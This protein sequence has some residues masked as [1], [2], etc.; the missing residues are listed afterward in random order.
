MHATIVLQFR[1]GEGQI[2][3]KLCD[4]SALLS[5][6]S[7][8]LSAY[9]TTLESLPL[10]RLSTR[11]AAEVRRTFSHSGYSWNVSGLHVDV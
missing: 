10:Q 11:I 2:F 3:S 6:V 5:V 1:E 9:I 4:R 8:S 7:H